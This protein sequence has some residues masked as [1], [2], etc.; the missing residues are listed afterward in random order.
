VY[1]ST[2]TE[3]PLEFF[4]HPSIGSMVAG[5][6]ISERCY[7]NTVTDKCRYYLRVSADGGA[8]WIEASKMAIQAT[9]A[10]ETTDVILFYSAHD[11]EEGDWNLQSWYESKLFRATMTSAGAVSAR[12]A[13]LEHQAG[14]VY[15]N[16]V[17]IAAQR[18][19]ALG[20]AANIYSSID[21]AATALV[22]STFR[23][24]ID[25]EVVSRNYNI[26]DLTKG[27]IMINLQG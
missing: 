17:L 27:S 26:L 8:T 3:F 13:I 25:D 18:T 20:P 9:W 12:F 19:G 22:K 14:I 6:F 21:N 11:D 10:A 5:I 1:Q 15:R 23:N 16:G 24:L 2:G 7:N 4:P